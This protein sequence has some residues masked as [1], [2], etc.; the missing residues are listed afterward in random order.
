MTSRRPAQAERRRSSL[1][2]LDDG[3]SDGHGHSGFCGAPLH[4]LGMVGCAGGTG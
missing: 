2:L 1:S 3:C 4:G